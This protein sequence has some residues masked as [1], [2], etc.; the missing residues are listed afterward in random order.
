MYEGLE[1]S[2]MLQHQLIEMGR[3]K[4]YA[5]LSIL[6]NVPL[7]PAAVCK[8]DLLIAAGAKVDICRHGTF[9][10]KTEPTAISMLKGAGVKVY[11]YPDPNCEY[12][13]HLDT[14]GEL[15]L[16]PPP[17]LGTVEITQTGE[18]IY[19][20]ILRKAPVISVNDSVIKTLETVLGASEGFIRAYATITTRP[21]SKQ[22]FLVFGFGKV[23]RGIV[24]RLMDQKIPVSVVTRS[25]QSAKQARELGFPACT[26]DQQDLVSKSL[27]WA[28]AVVTATGVANLMSD[29]IAPELLSGKI[30]INMGS[31]DEFGKNYRSMEIPPHLN[32][33]VD[34][35]TLLRYLQVTF[36]AQ[37]RAPLYLIDRVLEPGCHPYPADDAKSIV[38]Q[39]HSLYR[40]SIPSGLVD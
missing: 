4:P 23:G 9:H 17:R 15:A 35:P 18:D 22:R 10:P 27:G 16:L 29:Q 40:E 38:R 19:K 13:I 33:T 1:E 34:P 31:L 11:D 25:D 26:I 14:A 5:G 20:K 2:L 3:S 6:H 39:W 24:H 36:Y 12:D 8:I 7:T 21:I 32:F 37:N 30:L 28:S